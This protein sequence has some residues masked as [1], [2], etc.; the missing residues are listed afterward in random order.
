MPEVHRRD[1]VIA[2]NHA[3]LRTYFDGM[4]EICKHM[5]RPEGFA[6]ASP[7][8][9]IYHHG[10]PFPNEPLTDEEREILLALFWKM[11]FVPRVKQCFG[12][13]TKLV[14]VAQGRGLQI[15]YAEGKC[16]TLIPVDHAWAVLHGKP[17]DITI[18]PFEEGEIRSPKRLLARV[19]RNLAEWAYW[20]YV[21][22]QR[23]RWAHLVRNERYCPVIEDPAG[24][25][26]LLKSRTLPWATPAAVEEGK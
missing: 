16:V 15:E 8:E 14:D 17:I 4:V 9:A 6:F 13:A 21:V 11:P 1:Q 24:G 2:D 7:D 10:A 18:R 22:P 25:Y 19:E 26:P 12:N 20:G 3:F 5:H 23:A